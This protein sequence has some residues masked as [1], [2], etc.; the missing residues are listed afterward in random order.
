MTKKVSLVYLGFAVSEEVERKVTELDAMPH[1][2]TH[3]FSWSVIRSLHKKF[4]F[5]YNISSCD[6]RNYPAVPKLYFPPFFFSRSG[7]KGCFIG[8][9]NYLFLKH[10]SRILI[11]TFILS[12]VVLRYRS[13]YILVHGTHTP[14]MLVAVLIKLFS[15]ARI[16]I[17]L[18]DQHGRVVSSDGWVGRLLRSFD[19]VLMRALLYRFDAY[20]CLSF[21]FISK[22]D[23]HNAIVVPGILSEDFKVSINANRALASEAPKSVDVVFAGG[24]SEENGVDRLIQAFFE[25]R[26]SNARLIFYGAGPLVEDVRLAAVRDLRISYGGVLIGDELSRG[27]LS[28][29]LLVNPRPVGEEFAQTSFP[30]KLIEYMAT[31]VPVLTTPLMCIPDDLNDCL[32]FT[33]GDSSECILKAL[34]NVLRIAP[35]ERHRVGS[36]AAKKVESLCS[37]TAF[38]DRVN[39]VLS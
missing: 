14:F 24:I 32:Y 18:T 11:L 36:L 33:D 16:L 22:F 20:I 37:E 15:R 39:E 6:I 13:R 35:G 5:V 10:L 27:L 19:T 2:A 26:N 28:A 21:A 4:D 23:L 12:G 29:S 3:K 17:L 31:G 38:A 8:F 9:V 1:F 7:V 30:S 34:V 25:L